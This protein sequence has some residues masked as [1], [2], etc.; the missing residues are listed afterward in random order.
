M[1]I[2]LDDELRLSRFRKIVNLIKSNRKIKVHING[3]YYDI[4]RI[5]DKKDMTVF[6]VGDVDKSEIIKT[7]S[8]D[9]L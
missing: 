7:D 6:E 3:R 5:I 1:I 9:V 8:L 2:D 4:S